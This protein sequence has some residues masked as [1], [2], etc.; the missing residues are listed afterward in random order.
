VRHYG[1]A[2]LADPKPEGFLLE[3]L[4]PTGEAFEARDERFRVRRGKHTEAPL[5]HIHYLRQEKPLP[6]QLLRAALHHEEVPF[7]DVEFPL[8]V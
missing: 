4:E 8:H 2:S 1:G 7:S 3:L 5:H 6:L